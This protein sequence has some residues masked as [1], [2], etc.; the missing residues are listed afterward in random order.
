MKRILGVVLSVMMLTLFS[1]CG[2][3][4][5]TEEGGQTTINAGEIVIGLDENFPP[6]GFRD[7]NNEFTG[8]DIELAKA[9]G[10]KMGYKV[11]FQPI[12]WSSKELE[13]KSDKVDLLWNGLTITKDRKENME[14][15]KP[16]LKN[17]QVILV[18]GNSEIK[19]KADLEG[20]LIGLQSDSSAVDAVKADALGNSIELNEYSDNIAAFND[21]SIGRLDAVV[22]DEIVARY[23]IAN[24]DSDFV[25]L[26]ENFGDE[27]YGIAAKKGNTV[28]IGELQSA[29]DELNSDGTAAAISE[30]WFGENIVVTE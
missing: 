21:L 30:K 14:F 19:E 22:V 11:T 25:L 3:T 27:E 10:E 16:Y 9:A 13:L 28:L 1:A 4:Q 15:T 18:T 24:N 23:Y 5:T 12:D 6:M 7:D 29:L 20:K 2:Q 26:E 17:K 8:F